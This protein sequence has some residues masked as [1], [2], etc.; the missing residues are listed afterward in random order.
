MTKEKEVIAA[1]KRQY[2]VLRAIKANSDGTSKIEVNEKNKL[3][4][5]DIQRNY[6]R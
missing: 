3:A 4:I 6:T 5:H 2:E 1:K